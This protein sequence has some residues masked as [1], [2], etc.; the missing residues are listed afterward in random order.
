MNIP[1]PSWEPNT[2]EDVNEILERMKAYTNE[3]RAFVV[4]S[5]GTTVFSDSASQLDE[6]AFHETLKAVVMQPPD[7]KV[8]SM[9]NG[10]LMVRFAGPVCGLVLGS[11]YQDHQEDI[12]ASVTSGGL[13]DGTAGAH[14]GQ[15]RL[16]R[17]FSF[18]HD[19]RFP[20]VMEPGSGNAR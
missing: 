6:E 1:K 3:S 17:Q 12:V 18:W 11:F 19:R 15:T 10:N 7:F 16:A 2:V 8:M 20:F 13:L 5:C 14:F 4:Y 9:E